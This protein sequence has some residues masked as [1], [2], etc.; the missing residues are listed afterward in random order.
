MP[1][2]TILTALPSIQNN[3]STT[4]LPALPLWLRIPALRID[5]RVQQVGR[6]AAG[7][8]ANPNNFYDVG[9]YIGGARPGQEGSA[10]IAGHVDNALGLDGIFKH[11]NDL[12]V[13]DDVY[14]DTTGET[15]H[16]RVTRTMIY[17]YDNVPVN[18][19]FTKTDGV[20]LNLVTCSGTWLFKQR[21]YDHRLVVYTQLVG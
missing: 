4:T 13:G 15:L 9:W 17:S 5:A 8:M 21:T 19:L 2:D 10:V 7:L 20:Y 18:E 14:V 1:A 12:V 11:L 6:T 3:Q 16:F